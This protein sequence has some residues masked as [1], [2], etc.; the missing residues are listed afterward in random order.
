MDEEKQKELA[1]QNDTLCGDMEEEKVYNNLKHKMKDVK[2]M[3]V[4]NGWKDQVT[5]REVAG[6]FD[7]LI[8]S[9]LLQTIFHIEVKLTC[10]KSTMDH[11][12]KQL[13][14]GLK[15]I[16]GKVPFPKNENWKYVRMM[17]FGNIKDFSIFCPECLKFVLG[18][19]EDIWSRIIKTVDN[20]TQLKTSSNTYLNVLRFLLYNMFI[21]ENCATTE[22]LIK[23]TRDISD[24]M[25]TPD[26]IL[27]WSKEQ[28]K[29]IKGTK[30]AK[31]VA[32]TSQFGTGKTI[33]LMAKAK[34]ILGIKNT[35]QKNKTKNKLND[36]KSIQQKEVKVVVVIFEGDAPNSLLKQ[37]YDVQFSNSGAEICGIQ[38][39]KGNF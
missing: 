9:G 11:A 37:E 17:Y 19:N 8:V 22:Q 29:V 13:D 12:A 16:Q 38:G 39:S 23:K 3:V 4:I 5:K 33:L 6:E 36:T 1:K 31:R 26:N 25:T 34:E 35:K 28:F 20:P 21:Q 32:L 24:E 10:S 2:N 27:F 18:P 15:L 14:R 30:N 7:F